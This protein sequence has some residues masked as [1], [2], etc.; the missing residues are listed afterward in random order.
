MITLLWNGV[1]ALAILVVTSARIIQWLICSRFHFLNSPFYGLCPRFNVLCYV[2]YDQCPGF[3][4]PRY[5]FISFY[6]L[7]FVFYILRS[8]FYVPDSTF[9]SRPFYPTLFYVL[10]SGFLASN[11]CCCLP[12][13]L[14]RYAEMY[15]APFQSIPIFCPRIPDIC[16]RGHGQLVVSGLVVFL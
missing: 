7:R 13:W 14:V 10:G 9:C 1:A 4:V 8:M 6:L 3:N 15:P 5:I 2:I 12:H 16:G 11:S